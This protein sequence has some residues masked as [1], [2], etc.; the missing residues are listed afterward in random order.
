MEDLGRINAASKKLARSQIL[1]DD[2][3]SLT[4]LQLRSLARRMVDRHD[5]QML[6]IDY[7]QLLTA[8]HVS[9]ESRQVEV[10]AIS[11][12]IKALA[13][14]LRLPILCLAQLNRESESRTNNRPRMSDLRESGAIEQDADAVLLLHRE[15][16]FH[17][18]DREWMAQN[19]DKIG[20]AEL[21]VAKQRNGPTGVVDLVWDSETTRF[22]TKTQ[23]GGW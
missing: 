7:L 17:R 5:V 13:R 18:D 21:I 19:Q 23:G 9:R 14:E 1:I 22:K 11:R 20:G 8:P 4:V 3:P 6:V 2:T 15:E 16:Y 12:G 10:S